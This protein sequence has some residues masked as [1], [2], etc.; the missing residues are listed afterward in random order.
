MVDG[1]NQITAE[2]DPVNIGWG[3]MG[4]EIVAECT[5]IFTTLEKAQAHIDGGAKKVVISAPSADAP[6]FV[7][8]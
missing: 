4:I 2:R 3:D 1:K 8:G 7:M 5:G 6:M